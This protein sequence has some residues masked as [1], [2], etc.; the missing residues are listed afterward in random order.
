[1]KVFSTKHHVRF[2]L[3]KKWPVLKGL[4]YKGV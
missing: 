4:L 1:M 2:H 3:I